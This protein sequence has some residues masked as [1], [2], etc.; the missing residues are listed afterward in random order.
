MPCLRIRVRND[1]DV[2]DFVALNRIN[3]DAAGFTQRD[4]AKTHRRATDLIVFMGTICF[5]SCRAGL[6]VEQLGFHV[7][8]PRFLL[9]QNDVRLVNT[10]ERPFSVSTLRMAHKDLGDADHY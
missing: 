2:P 7:I 5:R 4:A 3:D 9:H 8:E 1:S 10:G 6:H